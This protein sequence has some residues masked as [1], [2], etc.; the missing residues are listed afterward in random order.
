[1]PFP[2]IIAHGALGYWDEVIFV[3]VVIVFL[4]MMANSWIRSRDELP[5]E[6]PPAP[7]QAPRA[8]ETHFELE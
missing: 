7:Q 6:T 1:M 5:E 4:V 3:S 2:V 8:S